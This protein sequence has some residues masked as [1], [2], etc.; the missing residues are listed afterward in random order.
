MKKLIVLMIVA[1][2]M[3]CSPPGSLRALL[4]LE[5]WK[6]EVPGPE[7]EQQLEAEIQAVQSDLDQIV[8]KT[9]YKGTLLKAAAL[10]F[11]D[12]RMYGPALDYLIQ[13]LA[14][15][16]ESPALN[17]YAGVAQSNLAKIDPDPE[18]IVA[19]LERAATYHKKAIEL[20]DGYM[21]SYF[22]LAVIYGLE[23]NQPEL[24][25][26]WVDGYLAQQ[27]GVVRGEK[28]S[29]NTYRPQRLKAT[30]LVALNR[31]A[32]AIVVYQDILQNSRN[33]EDQSLA[34]EK[35]QELKN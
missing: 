11:L 9:Q 20:D 17:Y 5:S 31:R 25:L 10:S 1:G 14:I 22:A 27:K 2:M 30:L 21:E 28:G 24:G 3:G 26:Q 32:E 23:L 6:G 13:A 4:E 8:A 16:P 33:A 12:S 18:Q 34:Q 19:K 35:L 29:G 15:Q 7:R